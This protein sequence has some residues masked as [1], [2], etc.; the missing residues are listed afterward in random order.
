MLAGNVLISSDN[1]TTSHA[2]PVGLLRGTVDAPLLPSAEAVAE[3]TEVVQSLQ[4]L[5][6]RCSHWQ[7]VGASDA[8]GSEECVYTAEGKCVEMEAGYAWEEVPSQLQ[9]QPENSTNTPAESDWIDGKE[10]D[11][12]P[13]PPPGPAPPPPPPRPAVYVSPNPFSTPEGVGGGRGN[14]SEGRQRRYPSWAARLR[15][16]PASAR[17]ALMLELCSWALRL[18]HACRSLDTGAAGIAAEGGWFDSGAKTRRAKER[19]KRRAKGKGCDR[20]W[21]AARGGDYLSRDTE[22]AEEQAKALDAVLAAATAAGTSCCR[23][24]CFCFAPLL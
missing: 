10:E 5:L 21:G 14:A 7:W 24:G 8:E 6:K 15:L 12:V 11:K 19:L 1:A 18:R 3:L 16:R 4:M 17:E 22:Q 2:G 20:S 23:N 13:P 9:R